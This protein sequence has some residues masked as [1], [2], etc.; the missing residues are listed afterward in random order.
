MS[1][2]AGINDK[3]SR[4]ILDLLSKNSKVKEIIIFGSRAKG[5][6][7]DGS[8]IDL[9]LRGDGLT[10]NDLNLFY[11]AYDALYLP[12]KLDLVVL[13]DSLNKDL[14]DHIAR[15]GMTLYRKK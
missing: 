14:R 3:H 8:D 2:A 15:V 1:K 5:T 10:E 6:H 4:I 9:A 11:Q 7:R 13:N 12:W